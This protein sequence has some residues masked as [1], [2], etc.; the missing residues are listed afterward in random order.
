M[1]LTALFL[2]LKGVN[3]NAKLKLLTLPLACSVLPSHVNSELYF[4]YCRTFA[5]CHA[6]QL[7]ASKKC[8]RGLV[9]LHA[10]TCSY[11]IIAAFP[12]ATYMS[13]Q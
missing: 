6:L 2:M 8:Q 1:N 11:N 4:V 10:N 7:Q 5:I 9:S 12:L 13:M 3:I